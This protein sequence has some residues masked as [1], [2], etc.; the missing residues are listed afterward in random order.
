MRLNVD[1]SSL[2][3]TDYRGGLAITG[4][5][6]NDAVN[7]QCPGG[8]LPSYPL[9][10]T[11]ATAAE[12]KQLG[13]TSPPSMPLTHVYVLGADQRKDGS[14]R[15]LVVSW[16]HANQWRKE[17]G[18]KAKDFHVT[19]SETDDHEVDKDIDSLLRSSSAGEVVEMLKVAG[20][21]ALDHAFV[22][23]KAMFIVSCHCRYFSHAET[24]DCRDDGGVLSR[25][26]QG[27]CASRGGCTSTKTV[28]PGIR[29][30]CRA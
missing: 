11:L 26:I 7:R 8:D 24:R 21:D 28:S 29:S 30:C 1:I 14:V 22:A 10:I 3:I 9:H 6:L 18:L 5:N 19:L 4:S 17:Q 15:W 23:A 16:N 12:R 20:E 2:A 27:L 25:L 13:L